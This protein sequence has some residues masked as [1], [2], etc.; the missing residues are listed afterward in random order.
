[1]PRY[2]I[3]TV[4]ARFHFTSKIPAD[5]ARKLE[6]EGGGYAAFDLT[7][8]WGYV[9][10]LSVRKLRQAGASVPTHWGDNDGV[11]PL[12][13]GQAFYLG[14]IGLGGGAV[15]IS[16]KGVNLRTGLP[17]TEG[18]PS[19][20]PSQ[21]YWAPGV[22]LPWIDGY[23]PSDGQ[24]VRQFVPLQGEAEMAADV[25]R[26]VGIS[27]RDPF[28]DALRMR[29][30][31]P[32]EPKQA[33]SYRDYGYESVEY[34]SFGG[35]LEGGLEGTLTLQ[36][37]PRSAAIAD[38]GM[39]AGARMKQRHE[40]NDQ[41]KASDFCDASWL[42]IVFRLVWVSDWNVLAQVVGESVVSDERLAQLA[43]QQTQYET[44]L[45]RQFGIFQNVDTK[46]D[47]FPTAP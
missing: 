4:G 5:V 20:D 15:S 44:S 38:V 36:S 35:G 41:V 17:E 19:D 30:F 29:F 28:I 18:P 8:D 37:M 33:S 13:H 45:R 42:E 43:K 7:P 22:Y 26:H 16:M 31:A 39:G 10:E 3:G 27:E 14:D 40:H 24:A 23:V 11:V 25:A 2:D 9:P 46:V 21:N 47:T 12:V 32:V 6:E 1:M 34:E